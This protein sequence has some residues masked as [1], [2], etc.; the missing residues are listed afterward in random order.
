[1]TITDRQR[2]FDREVEILE[3]QRDDGTLSREEAERAMRD[4][5]RDYSEDAREAAQDAYDREIDQ[6]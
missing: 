3:Q 1:M 4:L 5:Q 2:Q 6:W